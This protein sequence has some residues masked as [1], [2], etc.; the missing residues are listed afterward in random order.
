MKQLLA[1]PLIALTLLFIG[2][3]ADRPNDD[4]NQYVLS[5]DRDWAEYQQTHWA[6]PWSAG[7]VARDRRMYDAILE[8]KDVPHWRVRRAGWHYVFSVNEAMVPEIKMPPGRGAVQPH[9]FL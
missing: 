5:A 7:R 2:C 8:R 3:A 1:V 4:I 6:K 9:P